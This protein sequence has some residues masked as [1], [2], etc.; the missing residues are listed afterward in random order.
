VS[1]STTREA[2]LTLSSE[3]AKHAKHAKFSN[4]RHNQ[5]AFIIKCLVLI[6]LNV[7]FEREHDCLVRFYGDKDL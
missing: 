1:C 4:P 6:V 2:E 7:F 5:A 3:E